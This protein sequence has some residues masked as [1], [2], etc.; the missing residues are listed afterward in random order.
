V[1]LVN[2]AG[3]PTMPASTGPADAVRQLDAVREFRRRGVRR[4]GSPPER[5]RRLRPASAGVP[6]GGELEG[7][8]EAEVRRR[9]GEGPQGGCASLVKADD[10]YTKALEGEAAVEQQALTLAQT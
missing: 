6:G 2:S 7:L 9:D 5:R 1:L 10:E 3:A 8:E 4:P